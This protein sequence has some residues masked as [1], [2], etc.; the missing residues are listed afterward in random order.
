[1]T[2]RRLHKGLIT[3]RERNVHEWVEAS[4]FDIRW[5]GVP[6]VRSHGWQDH[7]AAVVA[8]HPS[9]AE[10]VRVFLLS[11][12]VQPGRLNFAGT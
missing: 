11:E 6:V 7:E 5:G 3:T 1:M 10:G 4:E 9:N 12:S 8:A 2:N